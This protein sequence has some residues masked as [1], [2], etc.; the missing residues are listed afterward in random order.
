MRT[1]KNKRAVIV[2]IFIFLG[3]AI[4]ILGVLILG[5][6]QKTFVKSIVLKSVFDD[7]IGLQT[8]NN[9]WFSGVKI[10][11]VKQI[12]F[13]GESQGHGERDLD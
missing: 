13:Y 12:E 5:G 7:V 10:G 2:G 4:F 9:V 1:T 6:Q 8:G 11:T 3:L